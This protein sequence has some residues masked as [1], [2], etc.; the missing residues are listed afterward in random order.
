MSSEDYLTSLG[1]F[2]DEKIKFLSKKD[3]F[4][5]CKDCDLDK[6]FIE[7]SHKLTLTCGKSNKTNCGVQITIEFPIYINYEKELRKL[8]DELNSEIN[9]EIINN[10]IDVDE[11]FDKQQKNKSMVTQEIDRIKKKAKLLSFENKKK[12]IEEYYNKRIERTEKC[13]EILLRLKDINLKSDQK[14]SLREDYVNH[15]KSLNEE[16]I[17]INTIIHKINPH[18]MEDDSEP[19]VKVHNKQYEKL[20]KVKKKKK[21]KVGDEVVFKTDGNEIVG[22]ITKI[23]R[24]NYKIKG[25]D[26]EDYLKKENELKLKEKKEEKKEGEKKEEKK[27]EK[28]E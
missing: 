28:E 9:W 23:I 27:E 1:I 26:G 12:T 4:L 7:E 10:Y 24:K 2:Y 6:E 16:Y 8:K 20:N 22:E 11:E 25:E 15:I 18:I 13:N 5:K 14:K 21:F 19:V 17:E 3:N